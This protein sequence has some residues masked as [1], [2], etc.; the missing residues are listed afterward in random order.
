MLFFEHYQGIYQLFGHSLKNYQHK[1]MM[2]I[3]FILEPKSL[4]L[5]L[6]EISLNKI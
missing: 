5:R 6:F 2:K 1:Y 4:I 3:I